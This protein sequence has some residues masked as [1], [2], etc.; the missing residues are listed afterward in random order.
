M[1]LA[2][3]EYTYIGYTKDRRIVKGQTSA[4][5]ETAAI[6]GLARIGYQV[7][8]ISLVKSFLPDLGNFLKG[9]VKASELG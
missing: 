8:S 1:R 5:T 2:I 3:L 7:V 4:D 9:T 6:N